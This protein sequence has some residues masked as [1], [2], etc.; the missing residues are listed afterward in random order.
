VFTAYDLANTLK[1]KLSEIAK[2]LVV[3]ADASYVLVV[4]PA[5]YRIDFGK[6][7]KALKAK[8][9]SLANEKVQKAVFK[10]KPG[11][12][13]AF[14]GLHRIPLLVDTALTKTAKMLFSAGSASC[15]SGPHRKPEHGN[16]KWLNCHPATL[17]QRPRFASRG[18]RFA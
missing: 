5:H 8:K 4:V 12:M 15:A 18:T 10:V 14:G 13:T 9:V 17:P 16:A 11:A 3:K 1:R 6:L 2:T 7:K